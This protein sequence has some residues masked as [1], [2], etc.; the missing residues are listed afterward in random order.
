[1]RQGVDSY[2]LLLLTFL[3]HEEGGMIVRKLAFKKFVK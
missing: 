1:M 2:K 3:K